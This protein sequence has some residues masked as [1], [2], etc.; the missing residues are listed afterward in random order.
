MSIVL[1]NWAPL[2]QGARLGGGV[3]GYVQGLAAAL[4]RRGHA[5]VYVSSGRTYTP[6]RLEGPWTPDREAMRRQVEA[7]G[8]GRVE[9]RR[10]EDFEGIRVFEI[11]NSPV[12]APGIFQVA[13]PRAE[14]HAP[15]LE[16]VFGALCAA[17]NA[18]VVHFHNIEGL[19]AGCVEA[20]R[21]A[22]A[23]VVFSLHNYH[24]VCP[25]VYL[26]RGGSTPCFSSEGGRACAT[27]VRGVEPQAERLE[28]ALAY[29]E[30]LGRGAWPRAAVGG[31]PPLAALHLKRRL[32]RLVVSA[33]GK[34]EEPPA[35][36]AVTFEPKPPGE[37]LDVAVKDA[38]GAGVTAREQERDG[39]SEGEVW[40]S[41]AWRGLTNEIVP[42]APPEP[43][44]SAHGDRRRAMV[45]ALSS[46]DAVLAVSRFVLEKFASMGVRREVLR[47]VAI[48]T[49]MTALAREAGVAAPLRFERDRTRPIRMV[50]LGYHNFFKGLHVLVE[51]LELLTPE[52][53]ARLDL[54]VHAKD[55]KP[56]VGRLE[57]LGASL[58]GLRVEDGYSPEDV[59]R[60]VTPRDVGVVPSVWW[61]NG[62]QTVMEFLACGVPVLGARLG[63]IP[64]LIEEGRNGVLFTGNDRFSLAGR[65]AEM[66]RDPVMLDRLRDQVVPPK[67][68]ET[69]VAEIEAVYASVLEARR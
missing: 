18:R 54:A 50:F 5:V 68:M 61:D 30:G 15:E 53:R 42:E 1:V 21:G 47:H 63:G 40:G 12:V 6:G 35:P 20:A 16:R 25:Q 4:V 49:R 33:L 31:E 65:L 43:G 37:A 9:A 26:M 34:R 7:A 69:H 48:G 46:C 13:E 38:G 67:G 55:V 44:E 59:P 19:S 52:Y 3:N 57:K 11:V 32:V 60:L 8:L 2:S 64:D 23:R 62:P 58:A 45:T 27:C 22:G 29:V 56:L 10:V 14:A 66:V 39:P 17:V 24:T 36:K 28:R 41:A 51:A